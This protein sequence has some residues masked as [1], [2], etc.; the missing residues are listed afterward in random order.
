M[1]K[2]VCK[3]VKTDGL[4]IFVEKLRFNKHYEEE[5]NKSKVGDLTFA[6]KYTTS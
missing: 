3:S 1:Q 5:K 2:N 4:T 6:K